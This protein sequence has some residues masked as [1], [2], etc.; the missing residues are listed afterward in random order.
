MSSRFPG[1]N[2]IYFLTDTIT[3]KYYYFQ[4]KS[5][6]FKTV[7]MSKSVPRQFQHTANS[8]LKTNRKNKNR[9]PRPNAI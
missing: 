3:E 5:F 8:Y 6:N 7:F 2:F 9:N 1:D 4:V